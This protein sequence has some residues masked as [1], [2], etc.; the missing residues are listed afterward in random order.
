VPVSSCR[1]HL[2]WRDSRAFPQFAGSDAGT[3]GVVTGQLSRAIYSEGGGGALE[4]PSRGAAR[5]ATAKNNAIYYIGA[6][7]ASARPPR[8]RGAAK[9]KIDGP[10]RTLTKYPTH[11]PTNRLFF[12]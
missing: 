7:A 1:A 8:G 11:P 5:E 12:Y 2:Q 3:G 6:R 9:K 10:P 4:G